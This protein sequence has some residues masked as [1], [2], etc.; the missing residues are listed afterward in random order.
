MVPTLFFYQLVLVALVWLC[1]MLHWAG[2]R[3]PATCPP[4][5]EPTPPKP[6]RHREP[7]PFAGLTTKPHCD[8]CEHGTAPRPPAPSPPH[9]AS[10]PHGDAV[11]KWI[12]PR[13]SAPTRTVPIAAGS[14]GGISAPMA[15]RV[16][17]PGGSCCVW[18]AVVIFSR[19][20]GPCSMASGSRSSLSCVSSRASERSHWGGPGTARGRWIR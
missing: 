11:A 14:A 3:G 8:T 16:A 20:S 7:T 5:S 17:V 6:K 18:S 9:P 2:P 19:P 13:I 15:I 10:C 1:V 12:P 4:P